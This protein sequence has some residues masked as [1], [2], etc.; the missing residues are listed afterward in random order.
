MIAIFNEFD[1]SAGWLS[2]AVAATWV[3]MAQSP[4]SGVVNEPA[5]SPWAWVALG[6]FVILLVV[7]AWMV[8]R[9]QAHHRMLMNLNQQVL[10]VSEKSRIWRLKA[11]RAELNQ[12]TEATEGA[13]PGSDKFLAEEKGHP[14][15]PSG[16]GGNSASEVEGEGPTQAP[17][18][19]VVRRMQKLYKK[20]IHALEDEGMALDQEVSL[21]SLARRV[22][23]NEKYVSQAI[24]ECG[25]T[26]FY[27]L[28]NE[29]R[30]QKALE[31]LS[32]SSN[33]AP[34]GDILADKCGF[35]SRSSFYE[36]FK[37]HTGLTPRQF[38]KQVIS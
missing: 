18:P 3:T 11:K 4:G 12:S 7:I 37:R 6:L 21:G 16:H 25:D 5:S 20:I 29:Y 19:D 22:S 9:R 31:I 10:L 15:D 27:A 13:E 26:S 30:V 34:S 35:G 17:D 36:V 28:I 14:T 8:H 38:R 33:D 23:S 24:S 1:Q 32:D 2:Q